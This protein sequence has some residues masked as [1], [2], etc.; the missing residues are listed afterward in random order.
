MRTPWDGSS[1]EARDGRVPLC[2]PDMEWVCTHLVVFCER[3]LL[4]ARTDN[5]SNR[6]HI[7]F[8]TNPPTR[9][10]IFR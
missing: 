8:D 6:V 10:Q 7:S 1:V 4:N 2:S 9:H 3:S 5:S